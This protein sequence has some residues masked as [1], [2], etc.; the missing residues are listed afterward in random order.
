[1]KERECD[2]RDQERLQLKAKLGG[3]TMT[4]AQFAVLFGE[5]FTRAMALPGRSTDRPHTDLPTLSAWTLT[6]LKKTPSPSGTLA[7]LFAFSDPG[8]PWS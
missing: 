4:K 6:A 1:M 5:R 7:W 8:R 3:V 2:T